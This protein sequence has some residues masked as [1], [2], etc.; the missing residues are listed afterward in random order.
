M[1]LIRCVGAVCRSLACSFLADGES[2][3]RSLTR[4]GL[5]VEEQRCG[6]EPR[7]TR[8][9]T[10][11]S[12]ESESHVSPAASLLGHTDIIPTTREHN[13]TDTLFH[14]PDN[15]QVHSIP[16]SSLKSPVQVLINGG[17][18]SVLLLNHQNKRWTENTGFFDKTSK[19]QGAWYWRIQLRLPRCISL[20]TIQSQSFKLLRWAEDQDLS[21]LTFKFEP[22]KK[23][24]S[25][26]ITQRYNTNHRNW[27]YSRWKEQ[28]MCYDINL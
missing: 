17:G 1:K 19:L 22:N 6:H 18:D 2:F 25:I 8:H 14:Q 28:Q 4:D 11:Y 12:R 24:G 16:L 23:T 10:G 20:T 27:Y 15:T 5:Q 3:H 13:V 26:A 21:W 9:Q 7:L